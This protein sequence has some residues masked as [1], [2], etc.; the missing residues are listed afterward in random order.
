MHSFEPDSRENEPDFSKMQQQ[1][2]SEAFRRYSGIGTSS[3][4]RC[5]W[6]IH[7]L[8][9]HAAPLGQPAALRDVSAMSRARSFRFDSEIPMS[10]G[11]MLA[12]T[13]TEMLLDSSNY[14]RG[15]SN[16][17]LVSVNIVRVYDRDSSIL[18]KSSRTSQ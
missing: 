1:L 8:L 18:Q 5:I 15:F 4:G 17:H 16:F 9:A 6:P 14:R 2:L 13:S 10:S 3:A 11:P 7:P 12:Q